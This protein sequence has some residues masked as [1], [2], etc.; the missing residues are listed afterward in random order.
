MDKVQKV[1]FLHLNYC[2]PDSDFCVYFEIGKSN[3]KFSFIGIILTMYQHYGKVLENH[4]IKFKF[5]E[6]YKYTAKRI[7]Y[8]IVQIKNS[9]YDD[10]LVKGNV[11]SNLLEICL[12]C[13]RE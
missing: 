13:W 10:E 9:N 12:T 7:S 4:L 5:Q 2:N 11:F 8:H 6:I 3:D 1:M